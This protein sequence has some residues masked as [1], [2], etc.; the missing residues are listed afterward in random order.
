MGT[1]GYTMLHYS[2][3][4]AYSMT[5]LFVFFMLSFAIKVEELVVVVHVEEVVAEEVDAEEVDA[6]EVDAE[7]VDA[8]A[9]DAAANCFDII[10]IASV[11]LLG[12]ADCAVLSVCLA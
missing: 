3:F 12:P 4:V 10:S 2:I 6:E 9:V 11:Q 7:E 8:G 5:I 1:Y